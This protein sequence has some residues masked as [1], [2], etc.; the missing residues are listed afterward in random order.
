MAVIRATEEQYD[1]VRRH[2]SRAGEERFAFLLCNP[3]VSNTSPVMIVKEVVLVSDEDVAFTNSGWELSDEAFDD[4]FNRAVRG[5]YAIVETH[6]HGGSQPAFS[7]IDRRGL[8]PMAE[9]AL[10]RLDGLPYGATVWGDGVICGE[11]YSLDHEGEPVSEPVK[12][13]TV[14]GRHLRQAIGR[15]FVTLDEETHDRQAAW[16]GPEGQ[17]QLELLKVAIVGLGGTGSHVVTQLAHLGI[18]DF[19]IIDDDAIEVTNLNRTVTASYD[20]VGENKARIASRRALSIAIHSATTVVEKSA[21]SEEAVDLLIGVDVI[22]GC[23]DND[24]VRLLLNR[25]SLSYRIPY[26]DVASD[27]S[28]DDEGSITAVGGRVIVVLASGPCLSCIDEIDSREARYFL[29]SPEERLQFRGAGYADD[30]LGPSPSVVFVN[31]LAASGLVTEFAVMVSEVRDV[32][33]YSDIDIL[34]L[35]RSAAGTWI[36]PRRVLPVS[37]CFECSH[38]GSGDASG[39][40]EM[41]ARSP[42]TQEIE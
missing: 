39:V 28:V 11:L 16:F 34:G 24:G 20:D 19:V 36:T 9:F 2:I 6:Y 41:L 23:V 40:R 10:N 35:E 5:R 32:Q 1:A 7:R 31:G 42:R 38:I 37:D 14:L 26:L 27:I 22:I 18:R 13:F 3:T 17:R 8:R 29:S 25:V 33:L 30:L 15:G 4:V 12:S 21:L